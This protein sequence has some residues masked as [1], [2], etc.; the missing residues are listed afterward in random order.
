MAEL[1]L[2]RVLVA[3]DDYR[4][5]AAHEVRREW[6]EE[7]LHRELFEALVADA[8]LPATDLPGAALAR[9]AG[10]VERVAGNRGDAD[11]RRA[12]RPLRQRLRSAGVPA[13]VAGIPAADRRRGEAGTKEG[14]QREVPA[15]APEGDALAKPTAALAAVT[16]AR[17]RLSVR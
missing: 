12:R 13:A 8:D 14:A 6:F 2:L 5:R 7:P 16:A 1:E 4:A 15:G 9:G 17:P 11:G 10:A 3:S